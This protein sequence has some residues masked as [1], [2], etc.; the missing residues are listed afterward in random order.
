MPAVIGQNTHHQFQFSGR[1]AK[2][3]SPMNRLEAATK[4]TAEGRFADALA[5]LNEG[6]ADRGSRGAYDVLRAELLERVG[7]FGQSRAVLADLTRS[8]GL[9]S[10][11][12]SSCE[13]ILGKI[14]LEDGN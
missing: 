2:G 10:G 4:L 8:R 5:T 9:T 6:T 13:F 1:T 3:T 11:E 7:R 14:E 12:R